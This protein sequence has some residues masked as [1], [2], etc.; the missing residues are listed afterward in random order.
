MSHHERVAPAYDRYY[1]ENYFGAGGNHEYKREEH[2]LSFFGSIANRIVSDIHPK[3]VLDAGCA[4]GFLVEALRDRGVEACGIDLSAYALEQ[5]REDIKPYCSQASVTDPFTSRF[6]LVVCI[7]TLEHLAPVDSEQAVANIAAFTDDVLF[8]STPI[9]FEEASHLNVRPPEYWAEL[10]GRY[11]LF[12]DVD[13]DPSSYIAPWA[14][15]FRRRSDPPS[16]IVGDYERLMWHFRSESI[17]LRKLS[18]EQQRNLALASEKLELAEPEL[19]RLKSELRDVHNQLDA[20]RK[21]LARGLI[22]QVLHRALPPGSRRR[23]RA[24]SIR[25][26]LMFGRHS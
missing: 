5:V 10:F 8:S 12:R 23:E 3:T 17:G 25:Q 22:H 13:Y 26:R 19:E 11:N 18:I 20:A 7:E 2:W 24:K 21:E 4:M 1:Y 15:R 14:V 16:R 9:H 6:D